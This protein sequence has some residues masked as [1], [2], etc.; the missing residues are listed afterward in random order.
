MAGIRRFE[1]LQAWQLARQ[2][3][4]AVSRQVLHN[5]IGRCLAAVAGVQACLRRCRKP[6]IRKT[7]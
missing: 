1:D 4:T 6:R 5:Q 2:V 7:S 3:V